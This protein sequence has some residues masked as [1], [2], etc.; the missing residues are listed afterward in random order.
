M[1]PHISGPIKLKPMLS[2]I[3]FCVSAFSM[4]ALL[5]LSA[6][7]LNAYETYLL[8]GFMGGMAMFLFLH[9]A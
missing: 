6:A 1:S 4:L 7:S 2:C 5:F 8:A 9:A 3:S